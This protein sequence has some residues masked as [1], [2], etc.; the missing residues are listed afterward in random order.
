MINN[1]FQKMQPR[2]LLRLILS[3]LIPVSI[4]GWYGISSST[5]ALHNLALITLS[6]SVN[7]TASQMI[8]KWENRRAKI[9]FLR[10]TL[11]VQGIIRIQEGNGGDKNTN[12]T[13]KDWVERMQVTFLS[14]MEAKPYYMQLRYIDHKGKEIVRLD[15]DSTNI[16]VILDSKLQSKADRDYF[17]A[18]MKLKPGEIYVS[19]LNLNQQGGKIEIPYKP[20]IRYATP[21][22]NTKGERQSLLISNALGSTLIDMVKNFNPELSDKSFI[23]NQ[24]GYYLAHPNPKKAWGFDLKTN[25]N[26]KN[27]YSFD[28]VAK[29][30]G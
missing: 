5:K 29:E 1:F 9:S 23:L 11:P 3:T 10:K 2:L 26:I 25:E 30:I 17:L 16:N 22:F 24:D 21:I 20:T 4:V 6:D 19:S 28:I 13:Y 15:S 27:D 8:N 12:S 7:S 18:T 14:M